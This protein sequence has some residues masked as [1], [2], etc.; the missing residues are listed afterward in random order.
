MADPRHVDILLRD[1][2]AMW[3]LWRKEEAVMRPDLRK[4]DLHGADLRKAD[5]HGAKLQRADLSGAN[6][7]GANL[8]GAKLSGANLHETNLYGADL[9]RVEVY[10]ENL[11]DANLREANLSGANLTRADLHLAYLRG[12]K[13][14]GAILYGA[15]L[16]DADLVE[17]DL[18]GADLSLA[19]LNLANLY[20]ADLSRAN[21]SGA[22][23]RM[24]KLHEANL[25]G[26]NLHEADLSLANLSGAKLHEVDLS[27]ATCLR[28]TFSGATLTG[29]NVYGI[30]AWDLNLD[31]AK[32]KDL[33]INPFGQGTNIT[34]DNMEVAQF[35]Y[36]LLS[37]QK[38][39]DVLDTIASKVVLILGRFSDERKPVLDALREALRSHL[40]GYIP[41]LFDFDPQQ[42]KPVFET[43]KTLANLAR[44]VIADLTDPRMVRSELTY[45][46]AN[47][48]TVP[49]QSIMQSDANL[50]PEY[51]TWELYKS[52]LPV[53]RYVDL[54]QLLASLTEAVI[55]PVEQ[56]I[57][58]RR[59]ADADSL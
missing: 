17:A 27:A 12:A 14:Y 58:A 28:T 19:N 6:L 52:F 26:T 40:N 10:G 39:R 51:G 50:P 25:N 33:R 20:G 29:C 36:L 22:H 31:G 21:L 7:S 16:G 59:L 43:V 2:V 56:H 44:F 1:G 37:N 41:V 18:S 11:G 32:Q 30:S 45:I 48:P 46:T 53:Y 35:L 47:V 15:D 24:A 49:V 55:T 8:Y 4:A 5:L 3:N 34:V 38:V 23:L 42:D 13:L 9:R 57:H 54:P